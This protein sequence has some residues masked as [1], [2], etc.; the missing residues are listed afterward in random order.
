MSKKTYLDEVCRRLKAK[1][2][3]KP[4]QKSVAE[5]ARDRAEL[6]RIVYLDLM[7]HVDAFD[8]RGDGTYAVRLA[9]LHQEPQVAISVRGGLEDAEVLLPI[10]DEMLQDGFE[11]AVKENFTPLLNYCHCL[12]LYY[13]FISPRMPPG[14]VAEKLALSLAKVVRAATIALWAINKEGKARPGIE[15]RRDGK[16]AAAG[17]RRAAVLEAFAKIGD[18]SG[19]AK[20]KIA[21]DV[22]GF[23]SKEDK[24][25]VK[26]IL[27]HLKKG[28]KI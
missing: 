7:R 18:V 5:L 25:D 14:L 12:W 19:K 15:A 28:G 26:T 6:A 21:H 4:S 8:R 24:C 27:E 13:R 2:K 16:G 11:P 10:F 22:L 23:L 9:M 3:N 17:K 20:N 1:T